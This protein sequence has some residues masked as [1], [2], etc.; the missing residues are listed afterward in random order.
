VSVK[1]KPADIYQE[2][3]N[4]IDYKTAMGFVKDWPMYTRFVEGKQWP[5]ATEETK[6]MPRPVINVCDQ[7]V[8][9]KRSN[10]LS[11]QLKMKFRPKEMMEGDEMPDAVAEDFS[12]MAENTW[13]NVDQDTLTEEMVND[14]IEL[15]SGI[16]HYYF[17]NNVVGGTS[18]AWQGEIKG[19]QI[20]PIDIVYG[21]NRLHPYQTQMQPFITV[22]RRKDIDVVKK[23]AKATGEDWQLIT[24]DESTDTDATYDNDKV[25]SKNGKEV[26]TYTKYYKE[27]GE[28]YFVEVTN[29][30]TVRKKSSLAP[31]LED[32]EPFKLY[33]IVHLGF[34]RRR[35]SVYYR[36]MIADIIPS[37]KAINWGMGMQLLSVQQTA[38]PKI[39]A[40]VGALT[41]SVTNIPGEVL[42]DNYT[43]GI[44]GFKY[45]QMPNTPNT[46]PALLDTLL[47]MTRSVTGITEVSTGE[48]LGANTSAA[49]IIALQNQAQKPNDAYMRTVVSA[50]K[51]IGEIW[52]NF[53]KSF[54][55]LPRPI[56][57]KDAQG[58][59]VGKVFEGTKGRGIEFDLI[60]D[61]GPASTYSESLQV[62]VLDGYA[63]RGWIDKYTHAD[64]MPST[65]L[66]QSIR[67][68][69]EEEREQ[70]PQLAP[71]QQALVDQL[72]PEEQQAVMANPQLLE[73]L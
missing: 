25:E 55:T 73:G 9:N 2:Y 28:V 46:V 39:I 52:E 56:V 51:Q 27:K 29:N 61:V 33:P 12:D 22:K 58:K 64:N 59:P 37:Q 57:G 19:E 8:E 47:N 49:A 48:V 3:L 65:V 34:K 7:T 41:Q 10:I 71:E 66:P 20:D 23:Q 68:Q 21:N 42:E 70:A 26:S 53:F 30:A 36:S 1:T 35:K 44:D 5:P 13:Y 32:A 15:G 24:A 69:F 63:D 50:T 43:G 11:Q 45:M 18:M 38:W 31:D 14:C 40:K 4:D 60:V 16:L 62:S 6:H 72:S 67:E 17:D 54:Y